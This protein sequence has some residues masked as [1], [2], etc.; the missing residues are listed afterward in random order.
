[1]DA[2]ALLRRAQEGG[3]RV[4]GDLGRLIV[5]GP[6]HLEPLALEVLQRRQEILALLSPE[7]SGLWPIATWPI[8]AELFT[9]RTIVELLALKPPGMCKVCGASCWGMCSR[10][11][12]PRP[13]RAD[14]EPSHGEEK[15]L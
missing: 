4:H 9:V 1:M 14:I 2:L 10:C 12:A 3:L 15:D 8:T 13:A 11:D 6:G 7:L 5:R